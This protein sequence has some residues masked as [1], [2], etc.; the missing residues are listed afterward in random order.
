MPQLITV[1][2]R[3]IPAQVMARERRQ[4]EKIQLSDRFATAI[5]SAAMR[6]GLSGTDAY[7]EQWRRVSEPC[8]GDLKAEVE[9]AAA[10]LEQEYG[11]DRLKILMRNQGREADPASGE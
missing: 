11:M 9:A 8:G 5:D 4:S 7:L 2:W 6:A 10:R 1:F 3:D